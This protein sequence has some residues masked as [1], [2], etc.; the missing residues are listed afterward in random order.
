MNYVV[1]FTDEMRAENLGCYGHPL[2]KTPNYDRLAAE[3]TLF[4]NHYVANPVCVGSRCSLF[5]GWYPHVNGFRSLLNFISPNDPNFLK[6]LKDAGYQVVMY[7]KNHALDSASVHTSLTGYDS[8]DGLSEEK[9]SVWQETEATRKKRGRFLFSD[10]YTMLFPA[11]DDNELESMHDTQIVRKGVEFIRQWK[12]GDPPFFLFIS[13]NNPHAPYVCPKRYYDMYPP[14]QFSLRR[15]KEG[16]KPEFIRQLRQYSNFETVDESVFQKCAAVYQGMITY[17][18]DM[19]GR[20]L[21]ALDQCHLWENTIVA[22]TSDHGDFAGDYGLVEK[23]P[24]AFYDNLVK[25]PLIIRVPGAVG[26]HRVSAPVSELDI[27]PTFMDYAQVSVGHDQFGKSLRLQ[28]EG[29]SGDE[30]A[31][32]FCEG[33]Y[34]LREPQCFEGTERDYSFLLK[35]DCVYYPKMMIQ[36][37]QGECVCRG[38]MM[39]QGAYKLI[40][41]SSGEHEFFDLKK[42]PGEERNLYN[43]PEYASIISRME[44]EMLL[45]YIQTSDVVPRLS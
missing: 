18:D 19:L 23:W 22:A 16:A 31:A 5:T 8:C 11:M 3:G 30:N 25:T 35:K 10:D 1:F 21:D 41:R 33:G 37:E 40:M 32:V 6:E 12:P 9:G 20:V 7:G 26:G 43:A 2:A 36:Q 45:W 4:E 27:F 29:D 38:T 28:L 14:E 13:I 34:D 39:R 24:N 17:C 42:D 15:Y 44:K